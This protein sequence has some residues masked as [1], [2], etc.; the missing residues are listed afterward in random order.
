MIQAQT[1]GWTEFIEDFRP[2]LTV[3]DE[4]NVRFVNI[5][6][7]RLAGAIG[8]MMEADDTTVEGRERKD[9]ARGEQ[10]AISEAVALLV[11]E[12]DSKVFTEGALLAIKYYNADGTRW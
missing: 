8:R 2:R 12:N 10:R 9:M 11:K 5:L 4:R 3:L 6:M 7:G 1:E